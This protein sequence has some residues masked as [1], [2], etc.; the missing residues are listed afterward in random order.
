MERHESKERDFFIYT[1]HNMYHRI[2]TSVRTHGGDTKDFLILND[3]DITLIKELR[4]E[5]IVVNSGQSS[6]YRGGA[7][8]RRDEGDIAAR[9][10]VARLSRHDLEITLVVVATSKTHLRL[11]LLDRKTRKYP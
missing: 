5:I 11:G 10:G 9:F 3:I 8:K 4:E 2:T 6:H 1:I 7:T